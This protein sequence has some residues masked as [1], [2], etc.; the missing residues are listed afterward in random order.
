MRYE[1]EVVGSGQDAKGKGGASMRM[2]TRLRPSGRKT[3]VSVVSDVHLTGIFAQMGRGII[4]SVAQQMVRQFAT[5]FAAKLDQAGPK[6]AE[7][8]KAHAQAFA[9]LYPGKL[10]ELQTLTGIRVA[11]DGTNTASSAG[12]VVRYVQGVR[13]IA[14]EVAYTSARLTARGAA[15]RENVPLPEL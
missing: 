11:A 12:D 8:V 2:V 1:T 4:Q 13:Q 3:L 14:G 5:R 6:Y 15:Q 10:D 9:K 7:V